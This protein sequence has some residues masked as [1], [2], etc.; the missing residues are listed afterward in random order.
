MDSWPP[1]SPP[2]SAGL[3]NEGRS[4]AWWTCF[5]FALAALL[6]SG[7][8]AAMAQSTGFA[9]SWP[10]AEV[11]AQLA[12]SEGANWGRFWSEV[13]E[14]RWQ[15]YQATFLASHGGF[16]AVTPWLWLTDW[17]WFIPICFGGAIAQ[18]ILLPGQ[19]VA[20][21]MAFIAM[22]GIVAAVSWAIYGLVFVWSTNYPIALAQREIGCVF[23]FATVLVGVLISAVA[24]SPARSLLRALLA[25]IGNADALRLMRGLWIADGR[26]SPWSEATLTG[27]PRL[28]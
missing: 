17:F 2:T 4:P 5:R 9:M 15:Q 21:R 3:T 19:R 14:E 22:C 1:T 18:S 13:P 7:S 27:P 25:G 10:Y 16:G 6:L 28:S 26:R 23:A 24:I 20:H 8:I 11:I 12:P